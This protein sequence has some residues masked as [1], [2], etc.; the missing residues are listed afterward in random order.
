M[1]NCLVV[2]HVAPESPWA[3][4]DALARAGVTP[5]TCRVFAGDAVPLRASDYDGVVV[6]DLQVKTRYT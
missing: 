6:I 5:D 1:P 2:Q 3:I 4:A